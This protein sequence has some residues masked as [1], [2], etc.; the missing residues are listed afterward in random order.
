ME[1]SGNIALGT[2]MAIVWAGLLLYWLWA[3]GVVAGV[4][5]VQNES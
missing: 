3:T 4:N 5:R 1:M 2:V